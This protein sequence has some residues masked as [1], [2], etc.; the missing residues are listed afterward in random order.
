MKKI[1]KK[2]WQG[3]NEEKK[4]KTLARKKTKKTKKN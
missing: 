3:K 2:T 1:Q 4:Q